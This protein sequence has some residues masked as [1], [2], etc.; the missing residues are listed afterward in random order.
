MMI[1]DDRITNVRRKVMAID[2]MTLAAGSGRLKIN[3][4]QTE[5]H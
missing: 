2:H 1:T 3:K 4:I 5:I